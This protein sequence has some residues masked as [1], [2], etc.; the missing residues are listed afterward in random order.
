MLLNL[1]CS[2]KIVF[3]SNLL[4]LKIKMTPNYWISFHFLSVSVLMTYLLCCDINIIKH[5]SSQHNLQ[6]LP[7]LDLLTLGQCWHPIKVAMLLLSLSS[8]QRNTSG[9]QTLMCPILVLIARHHLNVH[10]IEFVHFSMNGSLICATTWHN[11]YCSFFINA[12]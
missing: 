7:W 8:V 2:M 3:K 9:K 12:S 10:A 5:W 4:P 1:V 11:I 6:L